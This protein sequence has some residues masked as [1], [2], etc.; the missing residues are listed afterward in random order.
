MLVWV[1]FL[2]IGFYFLLQVFVGLVDLLVVVWVMYC[3]GLGL[4]GLG[5]L[6]FGC[7]VW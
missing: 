1:L 3:F 7:V 2:L 4:V 6:M 5:L